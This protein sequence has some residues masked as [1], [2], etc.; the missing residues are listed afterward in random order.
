MDRDLMTKR[1]LLEERRRLTER[2]C[3]LMNDAKEK[4]LV[5]LDIAIARLQAS[6][7][8][9]GVAIWAIVTVVSYICG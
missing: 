8:V 1:N 9:T 7:A 2:V 5:Q 6:L 3:V 4:Q